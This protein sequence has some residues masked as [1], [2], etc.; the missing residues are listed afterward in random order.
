M[1]IFVSAL[2]IISAGVLAI[3]ITIFFLE[4]VAA[5]ALPHGDP[6]PHKSSARRGRVAVLVPAHNESK[7]LLPTVADIQRQLFPGDRLLVVADNCTDDTAHVASA[8]GAEVAERDDPA[9]LGKGYALEF[10][11][12]HLALDPPEIVIIVDADCRLADNTIERLAMTCTSTLRPVQALDLMTAPDGSRIHHRVAEFA[13]RVKNWVRPLGL[14]ALGLPCQ[15][16]GTGMTFSWNMI[17]SADLASASLVEDVML[18]LDLASAGYPAVFFPPACVTSQF[19][20][21]IEGTATQRERWEQGHINTILTSVLRLL[22]RAIA[23]RNWGLLALTL[24]LAVPPLSLLGIL[25]AGVFIIASLA[26]LLGFSSVALV[27]NTA[28]MFAFMLAA[29]LAWLKYGREVLPP[30]ALLSIV[31]YALGKLGLYFRVLFNKMDARWIRTH[32][33]KSGK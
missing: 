30:S 20:S 21:S 31:P 5:I 8:A 22:W 25:V 28:N 3:P 4:V 32:R 19:A 12:R 23:R 26:A 14:S 15:L 13:W 9:K 33:T 29:F 11:I 6:T 1:E 2:L 7:G 16:L 27:I 17:G 18:G 10:G 24:D